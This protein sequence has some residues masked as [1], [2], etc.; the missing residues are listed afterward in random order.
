MVPLGAS[1][2]ESMLTGG[3]V[4][5]TGRLAARAGTGYN[6]MDHVVNIFIIS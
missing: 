6:N 3:G 1:V 4:V 5:R 2:L